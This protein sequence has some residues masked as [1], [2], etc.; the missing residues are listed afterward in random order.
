MGRTIRIETARHGQFGRRAVEGL[1]LQHRFDQVVSRGNGQRRRSRYLAAGDEHRS[2]MVDDIANEFLDAS[3]ALV[4]LAKDEEREVG[5][6][7]GHRS[8]P[9]LSCTKGLRVKLARFL[10]FQCGF[11]CYGQA[12][13]AADYVKPT[14]LP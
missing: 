1:D 14:R 7:Q 10:K 2:A 6:N 5:A 13:T 8:V 11:L 4:R 3:R 12:R 9:Y